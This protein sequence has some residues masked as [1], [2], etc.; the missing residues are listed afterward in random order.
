MSEL[1]GADVAASNDL[2]G[3]QALGGDWDLE[4]VTGQIESAVPFDLE[5]MEDYDYTLANFNVIAITDDGTGTVAGTLSKAILD[6]NVAP[7][8]DNITLTTGVTFTQTPNQLID[9]NRPLAK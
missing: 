3:N 1:T 2:T 4:I 5:A 9:S 6:A 8:D 7:G